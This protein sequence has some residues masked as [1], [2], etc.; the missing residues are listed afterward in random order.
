[1]TA[2]SGTARTG[3]HR[4][5]DGPEQPNTPHGP[6]PFP[7]AESSG[8]R[9]VTS[10]TPA[11]PPTAAGVRPVLDLPGRSPRTRQ[12]SGKQE[13]QSRTPAGS[14]TPPKSPLTRPRSF[15]DDNLEGALHL[16][17]SSSLLVG[18]M[19]NKRTTWLAIS[20]LNGI[21][22]PATLFDALMTDPSTVTE[23]VRLAVYQRDDWKCVR[24]GGGDQLSAEPRLNRR[25]ADG[26]FSPENLETVCRSCVLAAIR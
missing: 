10:R 1:M 24:C 4:T 21:R 12:L 15:R 5:W 11:A 14:R 16:G 3:G 13:R 8:S 17:P 2:A 22:P 9:P 20:V 7:V 26:S 23:K 18:N 19:N 6:A 25:I